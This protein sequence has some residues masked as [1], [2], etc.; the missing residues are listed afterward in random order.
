MATLPEL[1]PLR[2]E[3]RAAGLFEHRELKS[4]LQLGFL[5]GVVAT[6]LALIITVHWWLAFPLVPV[7]SVF[8]TSAAML[9]HEGSHKSFSSSATR[10]AILTYLTFPIFSGLS[11]LFWR[12]KHDRLHHGHPNVRG[13]DLDIHPF[14]FTS[15]LEDHLATGPA[16]RWFQRHMQGWI[17]WPMST[18]MAVGMR[19]S[20]MIYLVRHYRRHG[21]SAAWWAD[22]AS[23][24]AHYTLWLVIPS[25]IWGPLPTFLL[26][27]GIW[28]GV[29]VLLALIFAPAHMGLPI[30]EGQHHDWMH[31]LETSRN[32]ELPGVISWFFIGLDYQ[33]EHH[34]FPKLP[35][36]SMA[37][38]AAITKAWCAKN[39]VVYQSEPYLTALVSSAKFMASAWRRPTSTPD[40]V[41]GG[42][43]LPRPPVDLADATPAPRSSTI[44]AS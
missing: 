12:E 7:I 24:V 6:C 32:L 40:E 13:K 1:G 18:L 15:T 9:G 20:S 30:V 17:F 43:L 42:R 37:Q 3:L 33:V 26:Y 5:F 29:G 11:A 23:L 21:A 28:A 14:P 44:A 10:N 35:H 38:A 2:A 39:G 25:L 22:I 16:R 4:W 8:G 34:L 36:Q 41:R 31:Q 19:A 27:T